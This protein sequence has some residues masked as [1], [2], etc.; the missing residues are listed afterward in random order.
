[1]R[2]RVGIHAE[3]HLRFAGLRR[4]LLVVLVGFGLWLLSAIVT[5][6]YFAA[7][8]GHGGKP[9]VILVSVGVGVIVMGLDAMFIHQF[10]N[11]GRR[12]G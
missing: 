6:L 9:S 12:S 3:Q 7:D 4:V 11:G 1:M 5:G 2:Q 8:G 10:W